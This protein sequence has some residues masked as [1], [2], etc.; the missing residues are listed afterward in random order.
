M[1]PGPSWSW[2]LS[3]FPQ[4]GRESPCC[5]SSSEFVDVVGEGGAAAAWVGA[6]TGGVVVWV[7]VVVVAGGGLG[8]GLFDGGFGFGFGFGF[9]VGAEGCGL[10]EETTGAEI[11]VAGAR[12]T[13]RTTTVRLTTRRATAR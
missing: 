2:F 11:S 4:P 12:R 3:P 8:V 1:F 10:G 9:G 13:R 7:G 6:L 5:D